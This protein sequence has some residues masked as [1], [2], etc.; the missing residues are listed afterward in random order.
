VP[1]NRVRSFAS[2]PVNRCAPCRS[3]FVVIK[4]PGRT[5]AADRDRE[6][7]GPSPHGHR[8][9]LRGGRSAVAGDQARDCQSGAASKKIPPKHSTRTSSTVNPPLNLEPPWNVAPTQSAPA[10][11]RHPDR[12]RIA[13]SNL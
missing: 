3:G 8:K 11:H 13:L 1:A 7:G 12:P 2:S 9:V 5:G 10:V 6:R 4:R